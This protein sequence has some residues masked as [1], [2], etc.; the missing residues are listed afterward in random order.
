[1]CL[2]KKL[3]KDLK[4][5][6]R[7]GHDDLRRNEVCQLDLRNANIKMGNQRPA[8]IAKVNDV[9]PRLKKLIRK[10]AEELVQLIFPINEV[11]STR[12]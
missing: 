6:N 1:M 11:Q 9:K 8:L 10:R 5:F 2:E 3:M 12:K 7:A 4:D